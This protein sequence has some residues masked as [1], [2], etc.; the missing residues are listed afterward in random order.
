MATPITLSRAPAEAKKREHSVCCVIS[1]YKSILVVTAENESLFKFFSERCVFSLLIEV[2]VTCKFTKDA[3]FQV[4]ILE[5]IVCKALTSV[6]PR[7]EHAQLTL[8]PLPTLGAFPGEAGPCPLSGMR[9]YSRGYNTSSLRPLPVKMP[10]T[11]KCAWE[12]KHFP[13][14]SLCQ[15][16]HESRLRSVQASSTQ[17]GPIVLS[18]FPLSSYLPSLYQVW[19]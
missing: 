15:T 10:D 2:V 17:K 8:Y 9:Q 6:Q 12:A 11:F 7:T 3:W 16:A 13:S 5:L 14:E 18:S 19:P 1:R 4:P